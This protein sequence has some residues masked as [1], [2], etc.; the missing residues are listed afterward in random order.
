MKR[1]MQQGAL[2]I[3]GAM[4][5]GAALGAGSAVVTDPKDG[6]NAA[7]QAAKSKVTRQRLVELTSSPA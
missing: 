6:L 5:A 3:A 2:G 1:W 7:L 4:L